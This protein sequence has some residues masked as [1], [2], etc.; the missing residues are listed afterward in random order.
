MALMQPCPYK[1]HGICSSLK[2]LCAS[3]RAHETGFFSYFFKFCIDDG[4]GAAY[5]FDCGAD[6]LHLCVYVCWLLIHVPRPFIM[7]GCT[8]LDSH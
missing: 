5:D 3:V 4:G 2:L 1:N 6:L 7:F 8:I